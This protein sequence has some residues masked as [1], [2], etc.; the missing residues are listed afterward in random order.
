[1]ADFENIYIKKK[2][3]FILILTLGYPRSRQYN[4]NVHAS[5]STG[6]SSQEA[7][8]REEKA[9]N[10][11]HSNEQVI[12]VDNWGSSLL[13]PLGDC[14]ELDSESS[15]L[16]GKEAGCV[17]G[18]FQGGSSLPFPDCLVIGWTHESG[19]VEEEAY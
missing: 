7:F 13:G 11:E 10:S 3:F 8:G 2:P 1:M 19:G 16:R 14:M 4:E 12:T 18:W 9:A 5:S 15:H 17:K 6:K